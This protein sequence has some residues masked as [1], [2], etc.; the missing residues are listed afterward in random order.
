MFGLVFPQCAETMHAAPRT[1]SK[2]LARSP[3]A[4]SPSRGHQA[5]MR[6]H[7]VYHETGDEIGFAGSRAGRVVIDAD[8]VNARCA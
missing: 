4:Y 6:D 2:Q 8:G 1:S 3:V 7:I 5:R